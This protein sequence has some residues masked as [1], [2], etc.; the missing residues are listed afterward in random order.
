MI[1][2]RASKKEDKKREMKHYV[3]KKT[4]LEIN[5]D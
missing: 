4:A 2:R 5:F 1:N 3:K